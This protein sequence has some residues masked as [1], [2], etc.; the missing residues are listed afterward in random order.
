M[1]CGH[2]K[3]AIPHSHSYLIFLRSLL[4]DLHYRH[5]LP[6]KRLQVKFQYQL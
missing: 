1:F 5:G 6:V 3:H 4:A 2:G